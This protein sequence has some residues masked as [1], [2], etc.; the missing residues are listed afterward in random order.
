MA[1]SIYKTHNP[2]ANPPVTDSGGRGGG[3]VQ[4]RRTVSK[5][6]SQVPVEWYQKFEILSGSSPSTSSPMRAGTGVPGDLK[7]F[8]TRPTGE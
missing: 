2:A 5:T 3:A 8:G 6:V 7:L 4:S 1:P